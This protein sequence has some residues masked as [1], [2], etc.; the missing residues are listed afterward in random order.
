MSKAD[1]ISTE[2]LRENLIEL[3]KDFKA[4]LSTVERLA[5]SQSEEVTSQIRDGL[6]TYAE[7][8]EAIFGKASEQ[9]ERVY[10]DLHD[11]VERNPLSAMMIALGLGFVIGILTRSKS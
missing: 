4:L 5:A 11:T 8:G 9:A 6:K 7:K 2:D 1:D 3:R 10:G